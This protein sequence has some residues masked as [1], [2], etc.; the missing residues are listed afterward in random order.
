MSKINDYLTEA[1]VFFLATVD[2]N[3]PKLRPLGA[4]LE[5]DD[6]VIFGVGD[7]KEVYKQMEANPLVEIVAC[8]QDMHWLR[9]TGT[10]VFETDEK[11]ANA[12]IEMIPFLKNIYNEEKGKGLSCWE[13]DIS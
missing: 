3:Q 7:F 5:M 1:K 10:A 4:H 12:I 11:Y 2:G 9:Y 6:K 8:K 13:K